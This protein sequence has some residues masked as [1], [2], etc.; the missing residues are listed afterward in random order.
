MISTVLKSFTRLSVALL[1]TACT[2]TPSTHFYIL[3]S[4]GQSP[5]P[6]SD[7][8]KQ[9]LIGI[10]PV[11]LPSLLERKQIVTRTGNNSIQQAEFHQ[12]AAPLKDNLVQVLT[13]NLAAQQPNA[14]FRAYPWSAFGTVNYHVIIDITRFDT[15][16][17]QSANLE[18]TWAIM[19]DQTHALIS[20]GHSRIERPLTDASYTGAVDA[21]GKTLGEFSRQLSVALQQVYQ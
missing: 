9:R 17:K 20:N 6:V 14:I 1:V 10:G 8:A 5:A 18:A 2:A 4:T 15:T 3:E 16:P 7:P 13:Q 21:L 19:N 12:W 11:T